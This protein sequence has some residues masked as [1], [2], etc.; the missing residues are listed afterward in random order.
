MVWKFRTHSLN[1]DELASVSGKTVL[2]GLQLEQDWL[3]GYHKLSFAYVDSVA[4]Y[5]TA[6]I[7]DQYA[8]SVSLATGGGSVSSAP[9]GIDCAAD[10]AGTDCTET[11]DDGTVVTL[12][13]VADTDYTFAGWSGA[14]TNT[15]GDCVVTMTEARAVTAT[16]DLSLPI[17]PTGPFVV[18][19]PLTSR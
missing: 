2:M 13:A 11:Y 3:P 5:V 9:D 12:T 18:F 8:L 16:F 17:P 19:L 7:L 14:C 15:T 10:S 4:L 1:A 6:P